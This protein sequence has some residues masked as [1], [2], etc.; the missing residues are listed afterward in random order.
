MSASIK[1]KYLLTGLGICLVSLLLVSLASYYVSYTI[2]SQQ[3]NMRVQEAALKNAAELDLWFTQYSQM[4]EDLTADIELSENVDQDFIAKLIKN[5]KAKYGN[6]N[7]NDMNVYVGFE[8]K[9]LITTS[10]LLITPDFDCRT[11]AWYIQA[12]TSDGIIYTRPFKD[13]STGRLAITIAKA[14]KKDGQ[15]IGVVGVGVFLD[16]VTN[17]VNNYKFG[18]GSY[19]FLLD[20]GGRFVIHPQAE[21]LLDQKGEKNI[22]NLNNGEYSKLTQVFQGQQVEPVQIQDY[23][24]NTRY[25]ILSRIKSCD[26]VL[27]IAL[28]KDEYRKP[29]NN[30]LY[31]LGVALLLSLLASMGIML[32]LVD[33]MIRPIKTLSATVKQFSSENMTVRAEVYTK[34]EIGE[35]GL[36]FNQMADTIQ[37]YSSSLEEKVVLRTRELQE[38]NDKIMESID[39]A[40]R[41]QMA[42]LPPLPERLGISEEE[43]FV[44]W[45]PRD[46]V[47]GDMYWCRGDDRYVLAAVVDCTGHGVPGALMSMTLGSILDGL[48]RELGEQTPSSLLYD[49]HTRLKETLGQGEKDS[50]ANDGADIALC[51]MDKKNKRILFSGAKLSLF[52]EKD[53]Q[54]T[55]YKGVRHSVGY[56]RR[57]EVVF[58]DCDIEWVAGSVIYITTDGLLD[59]N[60]EEGKGGMGRAG[61][62]TFLQSIAGKPFAQQEQAL[63][64][65]INQKLEKVEQRDDITVVGFE[66]GRNV[67]GRIKL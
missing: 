11:R 15:I 28:T 10:S 20:P 7:T 61:F 54:I 12:K 45:K 44:V 41:L 3:V 67:E 26:W 33:N 9:R 19:A 65:L 64:Q 17:V 66:I 48:P 32:K 36:N 23:D 47:G 25:F 6:E 52:L 53:G 5:R 31:G 22:T 21:F 37:E 51:L 2:T 46:V 59:Q 29:L 34:D 16:H 8:D 14:L 57:K 13:F 40:Q 60:G 55:E 4:I 42:I 1:V 18:E 30:L 43:C 58:E 50:L 27:G 56:S 35:L 24:G 49:I 62:I 63:E 38:K 39:Y